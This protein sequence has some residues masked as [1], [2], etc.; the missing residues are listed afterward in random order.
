VIE[1]P[2]IRSVPNAICYPPFIASL[3]YR[4]GKGNLHP[5]LRGTPDMGLRVTESDG[6]VFLSERTLNADQLMNEPLRCRTREV[7]V[8]ERGPVR[9]WVQILGIT[10]FDIYSPGLDYV[11]G[12]EAYRGSSLVRFEVTWRHAD[13]QIYRLVRDLRFAL[14]FAVGAHA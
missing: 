7:R 14:P 8:V 11:I 12:I 10:A 4:D 1:I 9:A 2:I 5:L 6:R 13:D 3:S